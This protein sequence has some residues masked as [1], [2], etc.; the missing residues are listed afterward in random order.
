MTTFFNPVF[1]QAIS[2]IDPR[3]RH[4]CRSGQWQW[5][6]YT[7]DESGREEVYVQAFPALG[8][9]TPVSTRGGQEPVWAA[10]GRELFY[11]GEGYVMAVTMEAGKPAETPNPCSSTATRREDMPTLLMM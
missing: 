8:Q 4:G 7:S 2:A 9:K 3:A 5:L 10:N 11:R 6:A 1:F